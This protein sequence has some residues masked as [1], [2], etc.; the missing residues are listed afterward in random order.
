MEAFAERKFASHFGTETCSIHEKTETE[1][2]KK[3]KA[4][5]PR[6]L[7]CELSLLSVLFFTAAGCGTQN[8]AEE[9]VVLNGAG[10]TFPSPV[11]AAWT[12]AYTQ[13]AG[14][15]VQ[16]NYQGVGSGAG[17]NQLKEGILDF[18]GSDAPLPDEELEKEGLFQFPMLAGGV[19][20]AVN[21]P[22]VKNND[23][24][25]P[26]DVLADIF[27]GKIRNWND[28]RIAEVNPEIP[29]PALEIVPV[30]R[31]DSSGTTFLFTQY[32]SS[33][34]ENWKNS[35][36]TGKSVKFPVGVGGQ[37]NPG[38]CNS[39]AKISGSIGY[40]EYTYALETS[41][42]CVQLPSAAGNFIA[43]APESFAA[44]LET[45]NAP[46]A[47]PITGVTFLLFRRSLEETK[48]AELQ[49]YVAWCFTEGKKFAE[50]LHYVPI[51]GGEK[52]FP[53][54]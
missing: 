13:T 24:K 36:G 3:T 1:M 27:L 30:H 51:F 41:L 39:V 19:V 15:R 9:T 48:R 16:V 17:V 47:Y 25:L 49:K 42:A 7:F 31:A 2:Y 21:I 46:N 20:A 52:A 12:Y 33:V 11:Y 5:K 35:V 37:K 44:A 34:S 4:V 32:L 40:T 43:P 6:T 54:K 28:S 26:A 14:G 45:P 53:Q 50:D 38:V 8:S 18:A 10:A 29:L 23:L 22:G